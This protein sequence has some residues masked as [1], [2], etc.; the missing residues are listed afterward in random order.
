MTAPGACSEHRSL[1]AQVAAAVQ[2]V[3]G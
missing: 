2:G 1:M 3:V